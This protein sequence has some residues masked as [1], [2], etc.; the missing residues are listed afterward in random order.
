MAAAAAAG[1][2]IS[3]ILTV[4]MKLDPNIAIALWRFRKRTEHMKIFFLDVL[5]LRPQWK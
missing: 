3:V 2:K 5:V 4:A 1:L